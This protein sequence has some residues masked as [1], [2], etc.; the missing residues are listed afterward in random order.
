LRT[1][2]NDGEGA[3]EKQLTFGRH[4]VLVDLHDMDDA[5]GPYSMSFGFELGLLCESIKEI[6]LVHPPCVAAE[7]KGRTEIVTGYRRIL[8]LKQL[9]WSKVL[10]EDVSSLLPSLLE[11]FLFAFYENLASRSFNPIEKAMI[12]KRLDPLLP[13]EVILKR[14]M[15]LLS[16]PSHEGTLNFYMELEAMKHEFKEAVVKGLL[17]LNAVKSLLDLKPESAEWAFRCISELMLNFNQQI[18]FIDIMTDIS[19]IEGESFSQ[20]LDAEPMRAVLENAHLNKPQKAK[21]LLEELRSR[22]YPRLKRAEKRF[23]ENLERLSLP[24]GTRIDHPSCFE[25]PG[26]RLEVQFQDGANLMEKLQHLAQVSA[27]RKFRDPVDD[28]D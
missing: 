21:K 28:D 7:G 15:P 4:A 8:A 13:T 25:A 11:R 27:L 18:Q 10:C 2:I 19:A 14:L 24:E 23:Q 17:S 26:Y 12:L 3:V 9:G 20:I 6:G 16:L 22:R 1:R 5:P